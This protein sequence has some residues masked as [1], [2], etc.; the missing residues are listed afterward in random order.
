MP[1]LDLRPGAINYVDD[2]RS[3]SAVDVEIARNVAT[4]GRLFN[5]LVCAV[6]IAL[7]VTK[8]DTYFLAALFPA[9]SVGAAY[10]AEAFRRPLLGYVSIAS[11]L[12]PFVFLAIEGI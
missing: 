10:L 7:A 9:V 8:S 4:N 3:P 2:G 12:A 11:A 6:M 1:D 5:V